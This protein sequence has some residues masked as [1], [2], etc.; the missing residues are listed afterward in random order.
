MA[1][2]KAPKAKDPKWYLKALYTLLN[3]GLWAVSG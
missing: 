1:K 3:T 2:I